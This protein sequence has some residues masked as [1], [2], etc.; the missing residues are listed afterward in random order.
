M[1]YTVGKE[2]EPKEVGR[3]DSSEEG[4][5]GVGG[6]GKANSAHNVELTHIYSVNSMCSSLFATSLFIHKYVKI[7]NIE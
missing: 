4:W 7:K 5:E 1:F 6:M 3:D 2:V